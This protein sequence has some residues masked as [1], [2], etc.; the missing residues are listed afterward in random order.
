MQHCPHCGGAIGP[1]APPPVAHEVFD[2]GGRRL[3][4]A[5]GHLSPMQWRL[6]MLLRERFRR[7]VSH[8]FLA[9]GCHS[10]G[11]NSMK[12]VMLTLRR[13]LDATPFAIVNFQSQGYGLFPRDETER[14]GSASEPRRKYRYRLKQDIGRT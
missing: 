6:L 1:A 2:D 10:E 14:V 7:C 3:R 13:K 9:R 4:V 11:N 5:D 8:D 12:V